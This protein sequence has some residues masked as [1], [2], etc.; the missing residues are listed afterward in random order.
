MS[1]RKKKR[2]TGL[3]MSAVGLACALLVAGLFYAV[4]AYQLAGTDGAAAQS[5]PVSGVLALGEGE[6]V[7]QAQEVVEMG[8]APCTVVTRMYALA[9]GTAVEAVTAQPAAYLQRMSQE[10]WQPQLITGF[11]LAGLDA[12]YAT[13][14]DEC[15]LAA[16]DGERVYLMRVA[17]DEQRAYA[18]G[19]S[20]VLTQ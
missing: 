2:L 20:A 16:R 8:G 6:M 10:G 1:K 9:D 7:S 18:L 15:L 17:G 3:V 13:R 19:A 5:E 4:M 14:G 11:V 12:V